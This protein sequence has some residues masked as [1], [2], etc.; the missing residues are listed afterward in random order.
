MTLLEELEQDKSPHCRTSPQESGGLV[1]RRAFLFE[2]LAPRA[3]RVAAVAGMLFWPV[4]S[5]AEA[6]L[7]DLAPSHLIQVS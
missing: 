3:K 5:G 4:T 7:G 1:L 2:V 6:V